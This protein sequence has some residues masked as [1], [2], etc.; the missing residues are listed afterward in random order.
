[1]TSITIE[2]SDEFRQR[3][4]DFYSKKGLALS[5]AIIGL[6]TQDIDDDEDLDRPY[7]EEEDALLYS[8]KN[9]AKILKS[10]KQIEEGNFREIS[11]EELRAMN[12]W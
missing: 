10:V 8:E 2:M 1:M 3:A 5:D 9:V 7:S 4:E 12:K 6:I 11:I